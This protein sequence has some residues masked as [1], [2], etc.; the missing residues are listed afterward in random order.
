MNNAFTSHDQ[1]AYY[2]A[3]A[4]DRWQEA[5]KSNGTG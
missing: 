4:A 3:F 5:L 1:T 2:F